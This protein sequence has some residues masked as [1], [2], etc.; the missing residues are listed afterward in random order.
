MRTFSKRL[1]FICLFI[2]LLVGGS[3]LAWVILVPVSL[4]HTPYNLTI[5]SRSNMYSIAKELEERH[6][7]RNRRVMMLLA[8]IYNIDR[9]VQAGLY[10]L[11]KPLSMTELL[12]RLAEGKPNQESITVV[13]GMRFSQFRKILNSTDHLKHDSRRMSDKEIL[14]YL[15]I[16]EHHTEGLFFPSTYYFI[17]GSSDL[18]VLKQAYQIMQQ[19]LKQAWNN[20]QVNLPYNTP[21]E[22]LIMASIIEK[23]TSREEDRAHAS[24]VFVNRLRINMRLQTD[25]TVIYGMGERYHGKIRKADLRQDTPYNTYTRTGLPPTPISLPGKASLEAAAHPSEI[26]ALYFVARGD[27]STHFSD[28]LDQHNAAVRKYILKKDP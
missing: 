15:D 27:G 3:W 19:E 23:E 4:P 22:L 2:L 12:N 20:R 14:D 5:N 13:E 7:I 18:K 26:N 9:K 28:T 16:P 1:L 24:A 11:D 6:I 21:Y 17:P 25:P 8:R 10:T